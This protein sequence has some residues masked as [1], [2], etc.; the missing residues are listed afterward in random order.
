MSKKLKTSKTEKTKKQLRKEISWIDVDI[1]P[2]KVGFCP[3]KEAW[4]THV[5]LCG[6]PADQ[7]PS[8]HGTCNTFPDSK[9]MRQNIIITIA[10]IKNKEY[11][12]MQLI[13]LITHEC[14]HAF[15]RMMEDI[16]EDRPSKEFEAYIMQ[17]L[18][19]CVLRDFMYFRGDEVEV[20]V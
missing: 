6:Y 20:K 4:D 16:G 13:G 15:R 2:C 3:S 10:P 12:F 11:S 5:K 7:Y 8:S 18:V 14:M 9:Y 17:Y 19:V 1:L